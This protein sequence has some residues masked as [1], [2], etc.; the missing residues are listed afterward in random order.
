ME[1]FP[2]RTLAHPIALCLL[3]VRGGVSERRRNVEHGVQSSP[4]P[5]RCF[6]VCTNTRTITRV[7]STSV[8]VF[9]PKIQEKAEEL[10]LL[11]VR[12]GVSLDGAFYKAGVSSS[13]RPWRCFL[14][15]V[16]QT[17]ACQVF[18]TS[19]EVFLDS[20]IESLETVRLLHVRGGV[21]FDGSQLWISNWVFST[22]VEVFLHFPQA[23]CISVRLLHVRGGV[24]QNARTRPDLF[25]SSPRPWRCFWMKNVIARLAVVFSTSVEVFP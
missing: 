7:F 4:R 17:V 2:T 11:H 14:I 24:S 15:A 12:G 21:S 19:V 22:S 5:W 20:R 6:P 8:E 10:R 9:L 1:V 3:H 18:S 25:S 23:I 13:P 16:D